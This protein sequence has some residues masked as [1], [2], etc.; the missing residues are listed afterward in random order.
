LGIWKYSQKSNLKSLVWFRVATGLLNCMWL[1]VAAIWLFGVSSAI[2][3]LALVGKFVSSIL[4]LALWI[5]VG[6][7]HLIR[8]TQDHSPLQNGTPATVAMTK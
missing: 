4:L 5:L 7:S 8:I 1:I 3:S 2:P 6:I